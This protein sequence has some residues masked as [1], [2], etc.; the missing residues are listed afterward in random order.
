MQKFLEIKGHLSKFYGRNSKYINKIA[1]FLLALCTF[2]FISQ[3]V[4]FSS[5]AVNSIMIVAPSVICTFLPVVMTVVLAMIAIIMQ[6]YTLSA[7][8][9]CVAGAIFLIMYAVYFRFSPGKA[10]ALLL[11]PIAFMFKIPV[12]VPILLGLIGSPICI[13]PITMGTMIYYMVDCVKS[14]NTLLETVGE[15]GMKGQLATYA[16]QLFTSREMWST[17]IA[18]AICFLLVYSIKRMA[19]EHSWKIGIITGALGYLLTLA[20][21]YIIMDIQLLYIPLIIEIVVAIIIAFI[22]EFFVFT[23][24]YSRTEYLQFEDDE[25]YYHVKAV[26]KVSVTIPEKV[27]KR[28]NERQKTGVIDVE[29]VKQREQMEKQKAED[30]EIQRIIEEELG[31]S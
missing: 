28:I 29:Q 2:T 26:P 23:V 14:Y 3:N 10:V 17:M 24:D 19:V 8:I 30:S 4:G 1:Q 11:V 22:V 15:S 21:A 7:G 18:F 25:Y 16:Q 27:V 31:R 9:A 13:L 6:F 5:V 12:V 20:W